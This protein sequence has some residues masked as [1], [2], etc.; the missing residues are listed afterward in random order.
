MMKSIYVI[1]FSL[2]LL[3]CKSKTKTDV[4]E[5]NFEKNLYVLK[6]E[7]PLDLDTIKTYKKF[8]EYA[9]KIDDTISACCIN[10]GFVYNLENLTFTTNIDT[11]QNIIIPCFTVWSFNCTSQIKKPELS[12]YLTN[13]DTIQIIQLKKDTTN[14]LYTR[15]DLI[16][17]YFSNYYSLKRQTSSD[18]KEFNQRW[19]HICIND[20]FDFKT[21]LLPIF[22]ILFAI[23]R[24]SFRQFA[25]EKYKKYLCQLDT[26]NMNSLQSSRYRFRIMIDNFDIR[27]WPKF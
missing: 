14:I 17:Q 20:S 16:T 26:A 11:S 3:G 27:T 12:I 19:V 18:F 24:E 2:L 9:D 8:N 10:F 21:K 1:L 6:N 4:F 13:N 23:H 25:F 5:C 7:V 22:N 15:K